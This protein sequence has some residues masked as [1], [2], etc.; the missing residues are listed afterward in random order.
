[1][2]AMPRPASRRHAGS[3]HTLY[4]KKVV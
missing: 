1:V 2:T 3:H 4:R